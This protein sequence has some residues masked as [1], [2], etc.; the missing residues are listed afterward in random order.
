MYY[1]PVKPKN[2]EIIL[3]ISC[4]LKK[5][6]KK[7]W[8]NNNS[9]SLLVFC[10]IFH[11]LTPQ[12]SLE[13]QQKLTSSVVV[14]LSCSLKTSYTVRLAILDY[15][16][17][18][19]VQVVLNVVTE[20]PTTSWCKLRLWLVS[21]LHRIARWWRLRPDGVGADISLWQLCCMAE[22]DAQAWF[23]VSGQRWRHLS[24][25][26]LYVPVVLIRSLNYFWE[27]LWI[28]LLSITHALLFSPVTLEV[29]HSFIQPKYLITHSVPWTMRRHKE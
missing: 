11:L 12:F 23:H 21:R 22:T 17:L 10:G 7:T 24:L 1:E 5:K 25:G 3:H 8:R 19:W 16:W 6:K 13:Q 4:A 29:V 18:L 2:S 14:T 26:F 28:F 27:E 15:N 20:P 9:D